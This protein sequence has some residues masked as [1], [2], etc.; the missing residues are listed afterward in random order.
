MEF[1][2]DKGVGKKI[3]EAIK[4]AKR[5]VIVISPWIG[6]KEAELIR[7]LKV[8]KFVLTGEEG[9]RAL[10][11]LSERRFDIGRFLLA[12]LLG[13]LGLGLVLLGWYLPGIVVL[14]LSFLVGFL[15]RKKQLLPFVALDRNLHAKI[16]I[17]D[18]DAYLTSA[19]LTPSGRNRNV[20]FLLILKGDEGKRI[21]REV[22]AYLK[23]YGS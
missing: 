6:E 15:S 9:N 20:E 16:Y 1:Y 18:E 22:E 17:V 14:L 4:G 8:D 7:S 19:N 12:L 13:A 21:V 11:V 10:E 23:N 3:E 5:R 2:L